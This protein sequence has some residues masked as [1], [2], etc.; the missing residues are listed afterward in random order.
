MAAVGLVEIAE[1][2]RKKQRIENN[3]WWEAQ[4]HEGR[5]PADGA[6]VEAI[7]LRIGEIELKTGAFG[8][9][10]IRKC[11]IK[12]CQIK[13]GHGVNR[14]ADLLVIGIWPILGLEQGG[15]TARQST[16]KEA[17]S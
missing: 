2:R 12:A 10:L 1:C 11:P 16:E 13:P 6:L 7:L 5:H 3:T 9:G 14:G 15:R 17:C 8:F 4:D